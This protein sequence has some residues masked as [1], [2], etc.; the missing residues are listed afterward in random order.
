MNEKERFMSKVDTSGECWI[1]TGYCD[2]KMGYGMFWMNG[3][4]RLSHRVAYEM[5]N[6]R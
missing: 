6:A 2:K 1:W 3:T 5:F 4:M